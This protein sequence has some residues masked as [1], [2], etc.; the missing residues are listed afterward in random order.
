MFANM[1]QYVILRFSFLMQSSF[2]CFCLCFL[3]FPIPTDDVTKL[4]DARDKCSTK[5]EYLGI[6]RA[7]RRQNE[8]LCSTV[9]AANR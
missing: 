1:S 6:N 4:F 5:R 9:D 8:I 7:L 2:L 3:F